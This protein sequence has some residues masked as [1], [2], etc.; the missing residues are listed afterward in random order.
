MLRFKGSCVGVPELAA[1]VRAD[2]KVSTASSSSAGVFRLIR[3][4]ISF[5]FPAKISQSV[6]LFESLGVIVLW[7]KNDQMC[8]LM[9]APW[10]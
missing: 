2:V 5:T 7:I 4:L 1:A 3:S 8:N 6:R 9:V 10:Q